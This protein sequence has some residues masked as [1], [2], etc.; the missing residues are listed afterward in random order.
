VAR[1][2][3][4]HEFLS[5]RISDLVTGFMDDLREPNPRSVAW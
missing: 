5:H 3:P 4:Y 1:G 2:A